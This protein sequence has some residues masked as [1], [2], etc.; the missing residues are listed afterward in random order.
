MNT[1]S[2]FYAEDIPEARQYVLSAAQLREYTESDGAN[3]WTV[4]FAQDIAL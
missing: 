2:L 3:V 1:Y 4:D